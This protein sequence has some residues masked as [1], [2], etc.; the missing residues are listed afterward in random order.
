MGRKDFMIWPSK[1]EA[2]TPVLGFLCTGEETNKYYE[3]DADQAIVNKLIEELDVM[4]DGKASS[5]FSGK[6][7]VEKWGQY[8]YTRG[9]W[10]TGISR[11]KI[12]NKDYW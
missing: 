1:K 5:L 12:C 10:D 3:L 9:T 4:Y 6:F 8:E 2:K 11:T 7:I